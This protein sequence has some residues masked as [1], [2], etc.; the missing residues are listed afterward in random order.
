[1]SKTSNRQSATTQRGSEDRSRTTGREKRQEIRQKTSKPLKLSVEGVKTAL[2]KDLGKSIQL[3]WVRHT[4]IDHHENI[5]WEMVPD[6]LKSKINRYT[7][8]GRLKPK[9]ENVQDAEAGAY[10]AQVGKNEYNF[11]MYKDLEAYLAEDVEWN[12][13][14]AAR[15]MDSIQSSAAMGERAGLGGDVGSYQ[16]KQKVKIEKQREAY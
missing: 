7:E 1:M 12:K 16:P 5:G 10:T 15:P 2:E 14:E 3:K 4:T 6:T 11:L 13:E 8:D 9:S